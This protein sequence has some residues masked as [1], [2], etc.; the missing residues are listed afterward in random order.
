MVYSVFPVDFDSTVSHVVQ[1]HD[2]SDPIV[3]K[4]GIDSLPAIVGWLSNGEK[5]VLKTGISV[6]DTKSAVNELSA[7]LDGFMKKS[8]KASSQ[9]RKPQADSESKHVPV[10]SRS[11]YDALC[12]EDVPVCIIGAFRSTRGK[13]K[14]ESILHAVW[15]HFSFMN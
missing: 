2:V 10:L 9:A 1:V 11:N 5:H 7:L 15:E 13:E 4:L 14:L 6:K 12:G 8:K 3:Q